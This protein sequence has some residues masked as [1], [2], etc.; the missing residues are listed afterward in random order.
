MGTR[1]RAADYL[2]GEI[3]VVLF[4]S[5]DDSLSRPQIL[6]RA[7]EDFGVT[8]AACGEIVQSKWVEP[9]RSARL[10]RVLCWQHGG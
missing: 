1:A 4:Y 3:T 2:A 7:T 8:S 10:R 5:G 6:F 9:I